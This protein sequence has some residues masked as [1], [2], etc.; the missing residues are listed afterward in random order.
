M[1][2]MSTC[3]S[4]AKTVLSRKYKGLHY[5]EDSGFRAAAN[6]GRPSGKPCRLGDLFGSSDG[7]ATCKSP[8]I[9][10]E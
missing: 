2:R 7:R 4:C 8:P 5:F 10:Q 9:C 3:N 6:A 1:S